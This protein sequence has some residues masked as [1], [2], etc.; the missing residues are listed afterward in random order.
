[1]PA[2][3]NALACLLL[4]TTLAG[5]KGQEKPPQ[6]TPDK[7]PDAAVKPAPA[8]DLN[9]KEDWVGHF[10]AQGWQVNHAYTKHPI[11][12]YTLTATGKASKVTITLYT[13]P[14]G[15]LTTL[16]FDGRAF[17]PSSRRVKTLTVEQLTA[18]LTELGW[19]VAPD[20]QH[21]MVKFN[22]WALYATKGKQA[23]LIRQFDDSF[24]GVVHA[25]EDTTEARGFSAHERFAVLVDGGK[26]G[27]GEASALRNQ[28]ANWW[29][30]AH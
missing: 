9:T 7:T 5:C 19:Q 18:R 8:L 14:E 27:F 24:H 26:A 10:Q 12:K 4:A 15:D 2:R 16:R 3:H 21:E 20:P 29:Y 13:L 17:I 22:Q 11:S 1:M 28:L 23:R 25:A 6:A 30:S